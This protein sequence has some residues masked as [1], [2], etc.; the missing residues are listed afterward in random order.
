MFCA[1]CGKEI[2]DGHNFCPNCGAQVAVR[3]AMQNVQQTANNAVNAGQQVQGGA[4]GYGQQAQQYANQ[5]AQQAVNY[6]QQAAGAA[7]QPYQQAQQPFGAAPQYNQQQFNQQPYGQQPVYGQPAAAPKKSKTGLFIAIGAVAVVAIVA[8]LLFVWP[9]F[10]TGSGAGGSPEK[11]VKNFGAALQKMDIDGMIECFDPSSQTKLKESMGDLNS[12]MGG[13][14]LSS[15]ADM[16]NLKID[17]TVKNIDY[18]SDK[19]KATVSVDMEMSYSF[20]GQSDSQSQPGT[21]NMVKEGGNW[22]I[23]GSSADLDDLL[24][25]IMGGIY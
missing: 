16:M 6:G 4:A 22:Y 8:I 24:G 21:L 11:T 7:R 25:D 15:I 23:D 2:P 9:G 1:K 12:M 5:G 3:A 20:M 17:I 14:D 19:S 10:L 18:N 13:M